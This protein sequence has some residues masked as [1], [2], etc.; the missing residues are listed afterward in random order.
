MDPLDLSQLAGPGL[1]VRQFGALGD[2]AADDTAA[3][4]R[5]IEA[6]AEIQGAVWFPP[7]Q[8]RSGM[9]QMRDGVG[10]V[11]SSNWSYR[12]QGGTVLRLC[13]EKAS[14]LVNLC[15]AVGA[16]VSG[17]ALDG[18]LLG[19]GVH[20]IYLD[21]EGHTEE[22]TVV[23]EH[24]RV[25]QFTGDGAHLENV[26]GFI[27]R[28]N[29]FHCNRGDGVGITHWDG[30]VHDNIMI[31]N[32]K[33]GF[34]ARGANAAVTIT[35]NRIEWNKLGGILLESGTHYNVT[36]NFIDRSGG[37]ALLLQGAPDASDP[38]WMPG[39]IAITGNIFNRSGAQVDPGTPESC[40]MRLENMQGV[41]CSGNV[42]CYGT[43]DDGGGQPSPSY[44]MVLRGLRNCTII[45][46]TL[47]N[48]ALQQLIVDEGEHDE[49][50]VIRDNPG[51]VVNLS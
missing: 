36:G 50:T 39:A 40:H 35:G 22:D 24:C 11:G 29:L 8:Y 23:I 49:A 4:Q 41:A 19:E 20:G 6:A 15:G 45:G 26:W 48:A 46:N 18:G 38:R 14:C 12:R 7:G 17:L 21:G 51:N 3:I 34:A 9:L 42:F 37:P 33:F 16:R 31:A 13:D 44:A 43:N 27:V 2:D 25:T 47:N 5:A 30:W 28:N 1:N 10:L 32:G